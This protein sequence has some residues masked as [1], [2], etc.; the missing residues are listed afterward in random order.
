GESRSQDATCAGRAQREPGARVPAGRVH[1][2]ADG[3]DG[4]EAGDARTSRQLD[5]GNDG[6]DVA[7][8]GADA[9]K[10]RPDHGAEIATP[11]AR[12][13]AARIGGWHAISDEMLEDDP[14]RAAGG[15]LCDSATHSRRLGR[16]NVAAACATRSLAPAAAARSAGTGCA[17]ACS[18]A[19]HRWSN[20]DARS[21]REDGAREQSNTGA[22]DSRNPRRPRAEAA[23]GTLSQSG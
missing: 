12:T 15:K 19:R 2:D 17:A 20:T 5:S 18:G 4:R 1:G 14:H 3:R 16:A 6:H 23:I 10:V 8:E 22:G 11:G 9:G 21:G 7:A 13:R